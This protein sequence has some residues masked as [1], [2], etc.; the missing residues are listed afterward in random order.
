MNLLDLGTMERR[1]VSWERDLRRSWVERVA[2]PAEPKSNGFKGL[3]GVYTTFSLTGCI[4][5]SSKSSNYLATPP[6]L[7]Y[8]L[9]NS[10]TF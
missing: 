7:F 10:I 5:I 1:L 6:L 3:V 2:P 9:L 4:G 8:G